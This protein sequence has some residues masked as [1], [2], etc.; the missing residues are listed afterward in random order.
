VENK[1]ESALEASLPKH[2]NLI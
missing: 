1:T 2:L